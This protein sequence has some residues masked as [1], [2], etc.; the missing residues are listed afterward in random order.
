MKKVFVKLIYYPL[1]FFYFWFAYVAIFTISYLMHFPIIHNVPFVRNNDRPDDFAEWCPFSFSHNT[2][3]L[4]ITQWDN[5]NLSL[6]GL[7]LLTTLFFFYL[8]KNGK[9]TMI[10]SPVFIVIIICL[11]GYS[12]SI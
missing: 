6:V 2:P 4:K 12:K 1:S 8:K 11:I 9:W 10:L 7:S 5:F 3:L